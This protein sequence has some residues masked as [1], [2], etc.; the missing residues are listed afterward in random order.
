VVRW[1]CLRGAAGSSATSLEGLW[2]SSS[3]G[4]TTLSGKTRP[5]VSA[6]WGRDE[7]Q[8]EG[9]ERDE[10]GILAQSCRRV[11]SVLERESN[12]KAAGLKTNTLFSQ[13]HFIGFQSRA[14]SA[15]QIVWEVENPTINR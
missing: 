8:G 15:R 3:L 13:G 11:L 4:A 14:W 2:S 7:E 10:Q 9:R 1:T 12:L 6:G 5:N